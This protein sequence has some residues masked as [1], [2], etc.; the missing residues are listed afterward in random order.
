MNPTAP[1]QNAIDC[2]QVILDATASKNYELFTTVGDAGYKAAITQE[3]FDDVSEQL[4]SRL[5]SGYSITYF[6]DLKQGDDSIYLWKLSFA[7]GGDEFVAR[8]AMNEDKVAGI[9]I[10]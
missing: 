4:G 6:G 2:L 10:V 5:Q 8:M 7:D 3:M 1:P 9:F